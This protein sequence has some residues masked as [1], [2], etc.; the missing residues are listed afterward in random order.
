MRS[1]TGREAPVRHVLW[2]DLAIGHRPCS[3]GCE[4]VSCETRLELHVPEFDSIRK[5]YVSMGFHVVWEREPEDKKGYLVLRMEDIVLAFG[6][7][8]SRL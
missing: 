7:L 2:S 4:E 1:C 6:R 5:Y 3:E 8:R